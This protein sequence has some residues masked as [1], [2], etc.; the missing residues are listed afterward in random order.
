MT[1][2]WKKIPL[3]DAQAHPLYGIKG[4]LLLFVIG[5][6]FGA[7]ASIGQINSAALKEG[8]TLS[9]LLSIDTSLVSW[10]KFSLFVDVLTAAIV[11]VMA[12]TKYPN[13]RPIVSLIMLLGFP[14]TAAIGFSM[15]LPSEF[16][17]DIAKG[18]F[19]WLAMC[20]VW[21][22]YV[23]KSER[24]RVTFE[25]AI[26][27]DAPSLK[28]HT[29]MYSPNP[30]TNHSTSEPM[31]HPPEIKPQSPTIQEGKLLERPFSTTHTVVNQ[32]TTEEDHWA[33]A[34]SELDGDSRRPGI[35]AR[36][37]AE[38]D[39]DETKAKVAY[40]K[41]RVQ[42]LTTA[43]Q[44]LAAESERQRME[45][46][47]KERVAA[48]E[49]KQVVEVAVSS[50]VSTGDI[51]MDQIK[52][53][54]CDLD[55]AHLIRLKDSKRGNTLLH[56]C[57]ELD[58]IEEVH[59]LLQ[60]GADPQLSN[61]NGQRAVFLSKHPVIKKLLD[62]PSVSV[63]QL[64]LMIKPHSGLCP[65]CSDVI[66][67]TVHTC[68][69]C[70]AIFGPTS[71]WQVLIFKDGEMLNEV[72]SRVLDGKKPTENQ[73]KYLV[74]AAFEDRSLVNMV[75]TR[76]DCATLLHWCATYALLE[77]AK[78]LLAMGADAKAKSSL[79]KVPYEWCNDAELRDLLKIAA[80]Q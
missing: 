39:G 40:L 14:I 60:A 50:F 72:K 42:Q 59:A 66:P 1:K 3:K 23:Q 37:Y 31:P 4:W 56:L 10:I 29:P 41:S 52:L 35:W 36:A 69:N 33:V 20:A 32:S 15:N 70:R 71:A 26:P 22:T 63:E 73:V 30:T 67:V 7:L 11:M 28:I 58:M 62:G 68:P 55:K 54:M 77:E 13:F 79:G 45:A 21:V 19:R 12:F 17:N 43:T 78:I 2:Q 53:L 38:S 9:Q 48:K 51:S 74:V 6:V 25:H 65:R 75:G 34:M 57:A 24:V 64:K 61:N 46:V 16:G 80:K 27:E 76:K 44:A 47:A 8:L 49:R 18:V 5:S